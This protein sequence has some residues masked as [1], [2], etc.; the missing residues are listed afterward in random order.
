MKYI[1]IFLSISSLVQ[2]ANLDCDLEVLSNKAMTVIRKETQEILIKEDKEKAIQIQNLIDQGVVLPASL[3]NKFAPA[4]WRNISDNELDVYRRKMKQYQ[5]ASSDE[6]R[7]LDG[8]KERLGPVFD[9]KLGHILENGGHW[10]DLGAGPFK[11]I[12]GVLDFRSLPENA[13]KTVVLYSGFNHINLMKEEMELKIKNVQS[14]VVDQYV[15]DFIYQFTGNLAQAN[16]ITDLYGVLTYTLELSQSMTKAA[17]MLKPGGT[18][19]IKSNWGNTK[20]VDSEG[21]AISIKRWFNQLQG[22]I[23]DE[24]QSKDGLIVLHRTYEGLYV[25][26]LRLV[27]YGPGNPPPMP[28]RTYMFREN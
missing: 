24:A 15:G 22:L 21:N 28:S 1:F 10:V 3:V 16:L 6:F 27:D 26:S 17:M 19:I 12:E 8:Y 25:P 13:D 7:S 4:Q 5:F 11:A 14:V 23:Y 9:R 18:I 2:A 20:L